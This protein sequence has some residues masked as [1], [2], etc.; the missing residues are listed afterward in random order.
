MQIFNC[1]QGSP[2]WFEAR[3]GIPTASE[4]GTI[5]SEG[6]GGAPSKVRRRYLL[7]L[8]GERLTGELRDNVET[9]HTLRGKEREPEART[10]YELTTDN[11]VETV[12][13]IRAG[14]LGASPD[15]L[16]DVDGSLEIKTK[17]AFA[18]LDILEGDE[19]PEEHLPQIQCQ[20]HVTGRQWCDFVAYCPKLPIFIKRVYRDEKYIARLDVGVRRF[21]DELAT[22]ERKYRG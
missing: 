19:V 20:L 2:E 13:F 18:Q 15:G 7:E 8:L 9:R 22:L 12:G 17:L 1:E 10:L 3:R 5:M 4:A 11:L 6:R 14:D 16:I 21:L